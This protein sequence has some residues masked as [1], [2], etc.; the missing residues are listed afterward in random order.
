MN[1]N[2]DISL[3]ENYKSNSQKIRVMSENWVGKIYSAQFVGT[4]IFLIL[5]TICLSQI[6]NAITAVKYTS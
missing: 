3:A 4:R 6:Y 2:F 1:F 5:T